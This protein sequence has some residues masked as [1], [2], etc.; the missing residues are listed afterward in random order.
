MANVVRHIASFDNSLARAI[1]W[2][3]TWDMTRD[4]EMR[5]RD[6]VELV[7]NGLPAETDINL[8]TATLRQVAGAI[9]N[10]ADPAWAPTGWAQLAYT[11]QAAMNSAKPGSGFQ[12]AW[13]RA[14]IDSA[15][16]EDDLRMIEQWLHDE[17]IPTGLAIDTELRWSIIKALAANGKVGEETHNAEL[18]GDR[19]A[20]G[21]RQA[22]TATALLATPDGKAE[23]WR[24]LTEGDAL[25]NWQQRALLGG[26]Q[27][28]QQ[29]ELT[30]PYVSKYFEVIGRIWATR[31][32]EPAQ[33]FALGAYPSL[34]VSDDTVAATDAWLADDS[35]PAALRRLV[36]EGKDGVVRALGARAKDAS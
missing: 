10:Y 2:A 9:V 31:D 24:R 21:E 22:T 16:N 32:S 13:A 20:S 27:H 30:K 29:V 28:P 14:F 23:A 17:L 7:A 8:V 35:R 11:A 12:L 15:R 26:F 34:Q 3:A 25:P 6:Y 5:A 36:A 1:V 18:D 19:T 33:E 4:A